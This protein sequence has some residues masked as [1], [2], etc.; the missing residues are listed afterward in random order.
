MIGIGLGGFMDGFQQ[1]QKIR[2]DKAERERK[3]VLQ[4]RQDE[5]YT[6]L[7]SQRDEIDR[8]NAE[9]KS[10][11][12]GQVAAGTAKP[13]QFEDFYTRF[14]LPKLKNTY[15]MQGDIENADAVTKWG[16]TADAKR[17]AKLFSSALV[18]AQMGNGAGALKDVMEM[19]AIKG[20]LDHGHEV[21]GQEEI[22]VDGKPVGY[23]IKMKTP[24]GKDLVQDITGQDLPKLIATL[25]NPEAAY[26]SQIAARAAATKRQNDIEDYAT[27]KGID[28]ALGTGDGKLRGDA[29]KSLRER[30]DGGLDGSGEKFDDFS[31]EKKEEMINKEIELVSGQPGAMAPRG[32]AGTS[33]PDPQPARKMVMDR[34]TGQPVDTTPKPKPAASEATPASKP[35]AT[36]AAPAQSA[37]RSRNTAAPAAA[38]AQ[39][40][41]TPRGRPAPAAPARAA[42]PAPATPESS[43]GARPSSQSSSIADREAQGEQRK[44]AILEQA[45]LALRKGEGVEAV[46]A[47]LQNYGIPVSEWPPEMSRRRSTGGEIGLAGASAS[48]PAQRPQATRGARP[49]SGEA[50]SAEERKIQILDAASEAADRG[51]DVT[52][53]ARRLAAYG[54]PEE[55]WPPAVLDAVGGTSRQIGLGT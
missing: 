48:A 54:I 36:E 27:K 34:V 11:F 13:D 49:T 55:E 52:A 47:Q 41:A 5:E 31:D 17:G 30:Y 9:A 38:P 20:Y 23:R 19:G 14:T 32:S 1:G 6:R 12:D 25:A 15:L 10:T 2:D 16:E 28:R 33:R 22:M 7:K 3:D 44:A 21:L 42:E 35:A 29:V 43:R 4:G 8:I 24:D 50:A 46:A 37:T 51:D 40:A 39:P 18:K 53:I 26:E 45:Q